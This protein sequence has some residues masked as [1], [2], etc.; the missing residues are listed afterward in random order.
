VALIADLILDSSAPGDLILDS[1]GGSGTTLIAAEKMDRAAA[2]VELDPGYV[3][4]TIRRWEELTGER[5][6]LEGSGE[7]L[8]ELA[9]ARAGSEDVSDAA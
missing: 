5:A 2:L 3:D 4:T 7:T 9:Q 8:D 6:T 1:F